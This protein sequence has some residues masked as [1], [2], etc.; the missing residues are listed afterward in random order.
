MCGAWGIEQVSRI[1]L[2]EEG[3]LDVKEEPLNGT[4]L[5]VL[6][7]HSSTHGKDKQ[8]QCVMLYSV[9]YPAPFPADIWA[10]YHTYTGH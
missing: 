10:V 1:V 8:P 4:A 7:Q 2:R 9:S 5:G 6:W 3:N